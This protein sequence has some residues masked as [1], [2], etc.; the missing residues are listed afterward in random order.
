MRFRRRVA[1]GAAFSAFLGLLL[2]T[3]SLLM[4]AVPASGQSDDT[5][6]E[7][8]DASV[9]QI[10]NVIENDDGRVVADIALP[11]SIG[12][13]APVPANFGIAFNGESLDIDVSSVT[14]KLEVVIAIDTS[15]S[16]EG[17]PLRDAKLS[18]S[19]F[20]RQ[21]PEDAEVAVI[22]FGETVEVLTEPTLDRDAALTSIDSLI[23]VGQTR[24]WDGLVAAADITS[25]DDEALSYVVLLSDG[26]DSISTSDQADAIDRL[27]EVDAGF[28]GIAITSGDSQGAALEAVA[29][30]VD[31]IFVPVSASAQLGDLY[32]SVAD[33]LASRYRL[34]FNRNPSSSGTAVF[35]VVVDSAVA[36]ART[37]LSA[38]N[39]ADDDAGQGSD[40]STS[41]VLNLPA[42][43]ELSSVPVADPGLLGQ[44]I[45]L[46]VGAAAFFG[47][48]LILGFLVVNPVTD[49]RLDPAVGA[50]RVAGIG[51]RLSGVAERLVE[52]RD[53]DGELD[54]ALDAAGINLRPGEFTLI[55][56]V[57]VIVL[58]MVGWLSGGFG[59]AL[60]LAVVGIVALML[61]LNIRAS[62]RRQRFADQMSDTLGI[63][64]SSLRAGRGLPQAIELVASEAPAPTSEQFGR[65]MFETQVGR[66]MTRS[67]MDVADR[68]KSREFHWVARAFDINREL[69]G[70]LTEILDNIAE[71]LRDRR[72][73]DRM[74]R[75]LS[76]EG[77][78]S[79]WVMISLPFVMFLF[80]SWRTPENA[81]LLL[82]TNL[83]RI[84]IAVGLLGIVV[85][86]LWI[87][88]LVDL[89][90]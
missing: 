8:T 64:G 20:I 9:I 29:T 24:L 54:K 18:A 48:M 75:S 52:K 10:L 34:T 90:Y 83:G 43:P 57:I 25:G 40:E 79:G 60:L 81:D 38:V 49:V 32:Q 77:R 66:D 53:E 67:M 58:A 28:Y 73:V 16:M 84:M 19:T 50:D 26:D 22:G 11:G 82:Y 42:G 69:G 12:A 4:L 14:S 17:T 21:L 33:R 39:V 44:S 63:L 51:D 15:G 30:E 2:S 80:M 65:I 47:A 36:T 89:K 46:P 55:G 5:D 35:S 85:G 71:T 88:K 41:A 7:L 31:G 23:A 70:D 72:R 45:M 13:L 3:L 1:E 78:A 74:V 59:L 37:N 56:F 86:W 62:R 76:A 68:M 87:R 27:N 6:G 61:Y